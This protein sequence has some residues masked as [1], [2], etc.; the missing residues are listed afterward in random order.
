M[1][2]IVSIPII[3]I[4]CQYYGIEGALI[5]PTIVFGLQAVIGKIQITKIINNKAYGI[6][7]R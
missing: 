2:A 7:L 4:C 5:V 1:F 6:W 3:N